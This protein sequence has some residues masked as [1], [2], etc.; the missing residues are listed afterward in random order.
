MPAAELLVVGRGVPDDIAA[1]AGEN[2][3]LAGFV[4][5]MQPWFDRAQVVLVPMRSGGGT[6]LKVLDGLASGRP[7]VSTTM[8]A[9]GVDVTDGQDVLLADGADAFA[10]ATARVL[11]D[12]AL[13]A[14]LG[15]AGRDLAERVYDW[16]AI[17][18]RLDELLR[19]VVAARR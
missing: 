14:R 18:G 1:L 5:E 17:G 11:G 2:V 16:G 15:A 8:G 9:M 4:P 6:R 3:T 12:P 19:G 7:L 10:D 13:A